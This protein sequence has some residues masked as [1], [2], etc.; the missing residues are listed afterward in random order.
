MIISITYPSCHSQ[1]SLRRKTKH[2]LKTEIKC[3]NESCQTPIMFLVKKHQLLVSFEEFD[4]R[5]HKLLQKYISFLFRGEMVGL[6]A[7]APVPSLF[8]NVA[9]DLDSLKVVEV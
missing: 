3:Q 5:S 1:F 8:H 4:Q 9:T 7:N 2:F 6:D